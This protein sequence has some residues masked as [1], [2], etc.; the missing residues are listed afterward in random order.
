MKGDDETFLSKDD[1]IVFLYIRIWYY[2]ILI[3]KE[4]AF[5]KYL[6]TSKEILYNAQ[7]QS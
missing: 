2:S 5:K 1:S 3:C 4:Y 6:Y 7:M